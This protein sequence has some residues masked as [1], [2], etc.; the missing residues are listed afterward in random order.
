LRG[1]IWDGDALTVAG[2][3]EVRPPAAGEV[4]VEVR[5][6]GLCHS[7]LKPMDA[8]IPQEL[9]VILGHE[10]VGVVT[11]AGPGAALHPGDRV[12][13][14]VLQPC[15]KCRA[16]ERGQPTACRGGPAFAT[17]FSRG[18]RPV[19]QFVRLGAFA[20]R[21]VVRAEQAI[22]IPDDIPDAVAA[23]LGCAVITGF[24]AV[25]ERA[26]VREGD[27]VLVI[28][29]G[30]VGLN[31]VQAA[32]LAGASLVAVVDT[33]PRKEA[34]ARQLG[35][36]DVEIITGAGDIGRMTR[37]LA[38]AGFDAV[39]E[40]VGRADLL[41]AAV[42]ALAWGGNAV[43]VGLPPAGARMDLE[44]R[45]LSRDQGLLGCRMGGVDPH[46]EIPRLAGLYRSGELAVDPLITKVV[47]LEAGPELVADLRRGA[48]DRGVMTL[49]EE[50]VSGG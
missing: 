26:R 22:P 48:L 7:D 12:V 44:I 19:Q 3:L 46:R 2:D 21:T 49:T 47:P 17:P 9:P 45:A 5:A 11:E 20:E 10:A 35:A 13:L 27:R 8:D 34:I 39:F 41:E 38:P 33:N 24:G 37:G 29:A 25:T 28:G 16:C 4:M 43:I 50:G 18:G 36:T 42:G 14:S 40:C 23:L 15:G 31:V 1:L 30:G 6:A 32:R